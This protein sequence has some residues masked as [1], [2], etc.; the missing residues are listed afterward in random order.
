M[1]PSASGASAPMIS[2]AVAPEGL[3]VI[4]TGNEALTGSVELSVT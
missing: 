3:I 2:I 1:V 4:V